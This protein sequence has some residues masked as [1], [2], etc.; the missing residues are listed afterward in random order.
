MEST[1]LA[2]PGVVLIGDA[3]HAVTPTTGN[4]MN[5]ALDDAWILSRILSA[6]GD[7]LEAL[8]A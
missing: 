4:G 3:G 2:G 6:S 7:D 1:H 8:P 5:S